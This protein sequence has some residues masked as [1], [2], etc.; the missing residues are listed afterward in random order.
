MGVLLQDLLLARSLVERHAENRSD[1]LWIARQYERARIVLVAGGQVA[2]AESWQVL[3]LDPTSVPSALHMSFLGIDD[4]QTPVF[5]A[6]LDAVDP[7]WN[8]SGL[9]E[10][11]MFLDDR[12]S[13]LLVTAIAL[14]NW[15]RT[16][17]HCSRCGARTEVAEAGWSRRCPIDGSQHFPRTDPAVIALVLDSDDRALLGRQGRWQPGWF[18]TLAGFVEPGES[19]EHAVRREVREEAGVVVGEVDYLGSQP[20]PFPGSLMLGYHAWAQETKI[21]VDGKE[22]VEARWFT[23]QE[24]Q[25]ACRT[26]EVLLPPSISIARK[27]IERWY[28]A[29]IEGDWSRP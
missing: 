15:H 3:E 6:H 25:D 16:H 22:I 20:W 21:R 26:R 19:A 28:G 17:Q 8:W 12:A 18:S 5:S 24:L 1:Q 4:S 9:R 23:R 2:V 14:D 13:G 7:Q 29:P 11:G 27:L 10:I